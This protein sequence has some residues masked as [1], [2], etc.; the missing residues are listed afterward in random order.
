MSCNSPQQSAAALAAWSARLQRSVDWLARMVLRTP[1]IETKIEYAFSLYWRHVFSQRCAERAFELRDRRAGDEPHPGDTPLGRTSISAMREF[2]DVCVVRALDEVLA[3]HG[4]V[5]PVWDEPTAC[6]LAEFAGTLEAEASRFNALEASLD[7][8]FPGAREGAA[9]GETLELPARD[10][11]FS[12][13][14]QPRSPTDE[15]G[16]VAENFHLTLMMTEIPTIEHCCAIL[17]D[18]PDAPRPLVHD[19]CRQVWDEARHARACLERIST[20]GG[21]L[22]AEPDHRLWM[23][24]RGQDLASRLCLHQYF[25]E[26]KG[27]HAAF[28][29]ADHLRSVDPDSAQL[30]TFIAF[31]E[32]MHFELGQTWLDRLMPDEDARQA[33]VRRMRERR[34]AILGE[35]ELRPLPPSEHARG[36]IDATLDPPQACAGGR[37]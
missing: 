33:L 28:H 2:R 30:A 22:G 27:L 15:R 32:F 35:R 14:V 36:R 17:V 18:F 6:L 26:W 20:L 24:T 19:L 31:D 23:L 12:A 8:L 11:R 1:E 4:R 37:E 25:G 34:V 7:A 16:L 21:T 5:H 3:L 9:I 10:A 13:G 29:Y